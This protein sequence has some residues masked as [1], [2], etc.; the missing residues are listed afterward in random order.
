M[1]ILADV[2]G[3]DLGFLKDDGF[4]KWGLILVSVI[5]VG[6]WTALGRMPIDEGSSLMLELV[7]GYVGYNLIN[8]AMVW[9]AAKNQ[10]KPDA[11]VEDPKII[12]ANKLLEGT[13]KTVV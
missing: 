1:G 6:I 5:F 12:A 8:R 2:K 7:F 3:I 10:T 4:K 11:P 9:K 13:G